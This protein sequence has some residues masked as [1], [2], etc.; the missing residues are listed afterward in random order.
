[1]AG[2][3]IFDMLEGMDTD[4]VITLLTKIAGVPDTSPPVKASFDGSL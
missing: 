1:M 4:D 2:E 3:Q